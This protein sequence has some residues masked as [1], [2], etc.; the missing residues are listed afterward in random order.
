MSGSERQGYVLKAEQDKTRY[1]NE[2]IDWNARLQVEAAEAALE[3]KAKKKK[4]NHPS[5][6]RWAKGG[7]RCPRVDLF[8]SIH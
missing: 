8:Q 5:K 4:K 2:M 6:L 7:R 3:P 1:E